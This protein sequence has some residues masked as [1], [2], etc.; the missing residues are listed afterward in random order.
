MCAEA[1]AEYGYPKGSINVAML[2]AKLCVRF[3]VPDRLI[4]A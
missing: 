1:C 2:H 3:V 4:T